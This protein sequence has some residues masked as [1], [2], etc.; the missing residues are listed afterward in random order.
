MATRARSSWADSRVENMHTGALVGG[1]NNTIYRHIPKKVIT[2]ELLLL[3]K[4]TMY[5][6][7]TA[8]VSRKGSFILW[9][10]KQVYQQPHLHNHF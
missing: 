7:S 3:V 6:S 5:S 9:V 8:I 10:P 1:R 4:L 2:H